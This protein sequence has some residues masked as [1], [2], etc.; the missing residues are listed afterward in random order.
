[1]LRRKRKNKIITIAKLFAL[2]PN[3]KGKA[4]GE[5]IVG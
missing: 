4:K 2:N 5:N 1:M 3:A